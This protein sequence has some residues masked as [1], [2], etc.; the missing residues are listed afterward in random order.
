MYPIVLLERLKDSALP[1]DYRCGLSQRPWNSCSQISGGRRSP[2]EDFEDFPPSAGSQIRVASFLSTAATHNDDHHSSTVAVET[3]DFPSTLGH[4]TLFS[5][6]QDSQNAPISPLPISPTMRSMSVRLPPAWK[7]T[8]LPPSYNSVSCWY[9]ACGANTTG[10]LLE[11]SA[12]CI[13]PD[14]D[15]S[16]SNSSFLMID[17]SILCSK[18]EEANVSSYMLLMTRLVCMKV[19]D[20]L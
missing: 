7:P 19:T 10:F 6:T 9:H 12:V 18:T 3:S 5:C 15:D 2:I 8:K 16:S 11:E 4:L 17:T 14:I 20:F 1:L 13:P